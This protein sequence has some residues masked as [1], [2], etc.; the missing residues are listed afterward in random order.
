MMLTSVLMRVSALGSFASALI[1]AVKLPGAPSA[2]DAALPAPP[3]VAGRPDAADA[4]DG[5][6]ALVDADM[7]VK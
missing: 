2:A 4:A 7:V 1:C 5:E 6:M 3:A